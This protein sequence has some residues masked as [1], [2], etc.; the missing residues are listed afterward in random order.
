MNQSINQR[1]TNLQPDD[2]FSNQ[3]CTYL[4]STILT[5]LILCLKGIFLFPFFNHFF[6]HGRKVQI[7]WK[8]RHDDGLDS[9]SIMDLEKGKQSGLKQTR[10]TFCFSSSSST[11]L[12]VRCW[13]CPNNNLTTGRPTPNLMM[14]PE[15]QTC[16]CMR[17]DLLQV[18]R[19][20]VSFLMELNVS[21]SFS[22]SLRHV[23]RKS[24]SCFSLA[25]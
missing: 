25:T 16:H 2:P 7:G 19:G 10:S 23:S 21:R 9:H 6:F 22:W 4:I 18:P 11:L 13:D 3:T 5:Q 24:H 15:H 1:N 8:G 14:K 20:R 17:S 12:V